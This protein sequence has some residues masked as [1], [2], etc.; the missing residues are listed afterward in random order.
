MKHG[1]GQ[2]GLF[3]V[4]HSFEKDRH[5][6][7]SALVVSDGSIGNA[8]DKKLD[9]GWREFSAITLFANDVLRSHL[10]RCLFQ[11]HYRLD[12]DCFAAP[13][14]VQA[15]TRLGLNAD[16]TAVDLQ[17]VRQSFTHWANMFAQFWT[18]A[19]DGG[20]GVHQMKATLARQ[21]ADA[22]QQL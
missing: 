6:Q 7:S 2:C 16:T 21:P 8:A 22:R 3:G 15:F 12:G 11:Q 5:E 10:A 4:S 19:Y 1:L 17:S 18:L 9:L 13:N 14:G 20:V